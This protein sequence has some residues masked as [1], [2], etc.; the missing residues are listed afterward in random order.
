MEHIRVCKDCQ[1]R[2]MGCHVDCEK[3]KA[4]RERLDKEKKQIR[5]AKRKQNLYINYK[6]NKYR[7]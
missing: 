4:E 3:Y 1:D 5:E 2:H 7:K 6:R